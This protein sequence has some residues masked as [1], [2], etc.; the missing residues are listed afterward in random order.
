MKRVL[1]ILFLV[2]VAFV[3]YGQSVEA[4]KHLQFMGVEIDGKL[5]D[6]VNE[7]KKKGFEFSSGDEASAILTGKFAGFDAR[8]CVYSTSET[9]IVHTVVVA[10]YNSNSVGW[11]FLEMQYM[12]LKNLLIKKYGNPLVEKEEFSDPYVDGARQKLY[13]L[14]NGRCKYESIFS[15]DDEVGVI[16][17]NIM[18]GDGLFNPYVAL[19]Y[20]VA[21][22]YNPFIY[23]RF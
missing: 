12:G 22:E 10:Y 14:N 1:S 15:V 3:S 4:E 9:N 16:S 6:F 2:F 23:M 17:I 7:L 8:I 18:K 13:E 20:M 5:E 19:C 11:D 21:S